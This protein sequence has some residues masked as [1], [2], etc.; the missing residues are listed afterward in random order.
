MDTPLRPNARARALEFVN[1][2]LIDEASIAQV[3]AASL[4]E[5]IFYGQGMAIRSDH[6]CAMRCSCKYP[7]CVKVVLFDTV[8]KALGD[9]SDPLKCP[10]HQKNCKTYS[11]LVLLFYETV[12]RSA[13]T[14][15][16]VWDHCDIP[17][18]PNMHFD[19][20]LFIESDV[21]PEGVVGKRF[22]VD[23]NSHLSKRG[24]IRHGRDILKDKLMNEMGADVLRLHQQDAGM[25]GEYITDH[26]WRAKRSTSY[27]KYYHATIHEEVLRQRDQ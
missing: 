10:A 5:K 6:A 20:T 7:R 23:G 14:G 11:A 16:I 2:Q 27:T 9:N 19:A 8:R 13:Y 21:A 4:S 22:E 18:Q 3:K 25:W 12:A 17:G 1:A 26:L 24:G 15:I